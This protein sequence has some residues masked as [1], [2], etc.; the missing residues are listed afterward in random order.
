MAR[1][2]AAWAI[3]ATSGMTPTLMTP[4]LMSRAQG[5]PGDFVGWCATGSFGGLICGLVVALLLAAFAVRR[6]QGTPRQLAYAMALCLLCS[7][8]TLGSIGWVQ[9]RLDVSGPLLTSRE[10]VLALSWIALWGWVV[11]LGTLGAY[12][13]LTQQRAGVGWSRH[14]PAVHAEGA[15]PLTGASSASVPRRLV[16]NGLV[17]WG[18]LVPVA[19]PGNPFLLI[20][21]RVLLGRE[22]ANDLVLTDERASR[23]HAEILWD[24]GHPSLADQGS[25]NGTRVNGQVARGRLLLRD[26]DEIAIGN[27]CFRFEVVG[28]GVPTLLAPDD[29]VAE[30]T[31]KLANLATTAPPTVPLRP[32]A[33]VGTGGRIEGRRWLLRGPVVT[34]GRDPHC[35]ISLSNLS[36]SRLHAQVMIQ[37]DGAFLT[38]LQSSNGTYRNGARLTAPQPVQPGDLLVFG[39]V[40]VRCEHAIGS[41]HESGTPRVSSGPLIGPTSPPPPGTDTLRPG[42]MSTPRLGV[43]LDAFMSDAQAHQ[44]EERP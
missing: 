26:G 27:Q 40:E 38:D 6:R 8:F 11:P 35:T 42:L 29:E 10:I 5:S 37:P 25:M 3:W 7:L 4:G 28:A 24:H 14:L 33:L 16:P 34:I 44:P 21:A 22:A 18:R 15:T 19:G 41:E 17:P 9:D 12:V 43:S 31:A 1:A 36:V 13:L 39:T 20:R 23:F 2:A 30:S 32:L